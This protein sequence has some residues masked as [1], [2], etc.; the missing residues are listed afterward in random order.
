MPGDPAID[1]RRVFRVEG[2]DAEHLAGPLAIVGRDDRRVHVHKTSLLEETVHG[3]GN[4]A[5]HA[6]HGPESVGARTQVGNRA[7]VLESMALLL[8]WEV[9]IGRAVDDDLRSLNLPALTFAR[10]GNHRSPHADT[11]TGALGFRSGK[12]RRAFVDNNLQALQA[13][14]VVQSE[15]RDAFAAPHRAQPPLYE[16]L[17]QGILCIQHSLDPSPVLS[18]IHRFHL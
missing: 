11:G 6:E 1:L 8:H 15:K 5:A 7:Q 2:C 12:G 9:F 14:T 10:R 16:D 4:A 3:V 17:S 13:G 18:P